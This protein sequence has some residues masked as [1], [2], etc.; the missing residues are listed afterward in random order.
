MFY[1]TVLQCMTLNDVKSDGAIA[2]GGEKMRL[3]FF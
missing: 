2:F 1:D 3:V